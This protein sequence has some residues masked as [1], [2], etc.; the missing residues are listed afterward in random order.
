MLM[1]MLMLT[2]LSTGCEGRSD[3]VVATPWTEGTSWRLG[4]RQMVIGIDTMPGQDLARV[5]SAFRDRS[6]RIF[7]AD[8]ASNEL[9]VFDAAGQ[10]ER[11]IGGSG[12]GPEQFGLLAGA[13]LVADD[14][15]M[16]YDARGSRVAYWSTQGTLH[17]T[18]P[19]YSRPMPLYVVGRLADGSLIGVSTASSSRPPQGTIYVDSAAVVLLAADGTATSTVIPFAWRTIYAAPMP[20]G[21]TGTVFQPLTLEPTGTV[22]PAGDNIYLGY[23]DQWSVVRYAANGLVVDTLRRQARRQPF[24]G[25]LRDAWLDELAARGVDPLQQAELRRYFATFPV[26]DSLPAYDQL[27]IDADQNA[28]V[29]AFPEP[30]P[31]QHRWSVFSATG[32]WLGEVSLPASVRPTQ[33]GSDFLVAVTLDE[34]GVEHVAVFALD[35][36]GGARPRR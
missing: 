17:R 4:D 33:I 20:S 34:N 26:P 35:R 36:R 15:V 2:L 8:G 23:G 25:T 13:W 22:V 19:V 6:G 9:R 5:R 3:H 7:I 10:L 30:K 16:T 24:T 12:G 14:T 28:W 31:V 18:V 29:R 27:L 11:R 1:G 32:V 21:G